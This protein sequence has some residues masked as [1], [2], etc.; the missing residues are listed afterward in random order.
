MLHIIY[1]DNTS[2]VELRGLSNSVD[3]QWVNDA[4]VTMTL[5]DLSGNLVGGQTWPITLSYIANSR[6]R[7]TGSFSHLA[8]V[9]PGT[10]YEATISAILQSGSEARWTEPILAKERGKQQQLY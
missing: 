1:K 5:K 7:Y 10:T 2:T 3:G 6:G 9:V 4:I 8:E